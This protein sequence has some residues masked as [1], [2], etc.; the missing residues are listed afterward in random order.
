MGF[1]NALGRCYNYEE[2]R[3]SCVKKDGMDVKE[4]VEG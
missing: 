2:D 1:L 4:T 3:L